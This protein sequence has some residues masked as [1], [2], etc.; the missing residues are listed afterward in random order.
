VREDKQT[1]LCFTP[2]L[3]LAFFPAEK[4]RRWRGFGFAVGWLA[5]PVARFFRIKG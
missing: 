2:A 1:D 3:I 4:E 5:H